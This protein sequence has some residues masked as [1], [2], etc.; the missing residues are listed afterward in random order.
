MTVKIIGIITV[1]SKLSKPKEKFGFCF[2]F[3]RLD[4]SE[5]SCLNGFDSNYI[6]ASDSQA[7]DSSSSLFSLSY[8]IQASRFDC[9]NH[10]SVCLQILYNIP[11]SR[12]TNLK[13]TFSER[14]NTEK[15][16]FVQLLLKPVW[17]FCCCC[18]H[19]DQS[20]FYFRNCGAFWVQ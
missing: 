11:Q 2:F 7:A 14:H 15:V 1:S 16:S 20:H 6:P 8:F 4:I 18:C 10:L 12:I 3:L 9:H 17:R 13:K 5:A 19:N